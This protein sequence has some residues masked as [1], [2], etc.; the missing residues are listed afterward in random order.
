M[1]ELYLDPQYTTKLSLRETE[2]AIKFTKDF[3]QDNFAAELNLERVSAP[4]FTRKGTGIN[5]DL[6]GVELQSRTFRMSKA[7]GGVH[8]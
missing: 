4:L 1:P 2:K 8:V 3:F 6:N 5:D 7:D